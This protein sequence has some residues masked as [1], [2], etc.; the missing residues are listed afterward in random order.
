MVVTRDRAREL[1]GAIERL[2]ALPGSPPVIVVDNASSDGTVEAVSAAHPDVRTIAL[3]RNAGAAG[4]NVGVEAASTPY[5]AFSDDD[6]WWAAD[7]LAR[8]EAHLDAHPRAAL[9]AGRVLVGTE[10]MLDPTCTAM[11]ESPLPRE[12]DLP[13]PSILGFVACGAVVRR[14][15]FLAVGGFAEPYGVGG[16]EALLAIDLAAA[17]WGL[18]YCE[19]LVAHHHPSAARDPAAR[20]ARMVRNDL[21]TAWLRRP[22][23]VAVRATAT[24]VVRSP[25][26][27]AARRGLLQALRGGAWTLRGRRT[28]SRDL[29]QRLRM[30]APA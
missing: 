29:E 2:V 17:G 25:G 1:L 6:S 18:A 22:L 8:A 28:V 11:A 27:A 15:A 12:T 13:G 7:A 3:A 4:R 21:W 26:D 16:E 23:P 19:D 9:L 24:A 20:R 5:V 14:D 10:E 30:L